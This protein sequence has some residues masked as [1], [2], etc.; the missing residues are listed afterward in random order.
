MLEIDP[1]KFI[2][3]VHA[4]FFCSLFQN[5]PLRSCHFVLQSASA[6]VVSRSFRWANIDVILVNNRAQS[7]VRN[8]VS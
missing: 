2:R 8:S 4:E 5:F 3:S 1:L 7:N 6:F